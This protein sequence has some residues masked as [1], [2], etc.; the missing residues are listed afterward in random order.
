MSQKPTAYEKSLQLLNLRLQ[1]EAELRQKLG[2]KNYPPAEIE[3]VIRRLKRI[4][5][6][7]DL[8]YAQA[9]ILARDRFRPRGQRVLELELKKRGIASDIIEQAL[10]LLDAERDEDAV[11]QD[12]IV[13][14]KRKYQ[15]LPKDIA[16]RRLLSYLARR[17]YGYGQVK[18]YL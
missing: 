9:F 6:V 10:A 1:S 17:G 16:Q 18:K 5:L 3:K 15:H 14:Q 12:L 13:R 7:D 11:L 8:K 4:G 2:R